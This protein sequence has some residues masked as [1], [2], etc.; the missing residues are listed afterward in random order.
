MEIEKELRYD[1]ISTAHCG[2]KMKWFI[3]YWPDSNVS[4][5]DLLIENEPEFD[6][7]DFLDWE[8]I[9]KRVI[10]FKI[11]L[12]KELREIAAPVIEDFLQKNQVDIIL[13]SKLYKHSI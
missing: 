13:T 12:Y 3:F 2:Q 6:E 8:D 10:H 5:C 11:N 4:K 9:L 7:L 1:N